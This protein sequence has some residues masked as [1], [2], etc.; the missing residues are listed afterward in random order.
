[1]LTVS[2]YENGAQPKAD[3]CLSSTYFSLFF[4]FFSFYFSLNFL[5]MIVF[6]RLTVIIWLTLYPTMFTR[7]G[8]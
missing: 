4:L 8:G 2:E 1:M 3:S 5:Y 7:A 6:H